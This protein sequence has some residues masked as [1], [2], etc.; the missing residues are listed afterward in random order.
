M[1]FFE[2]ER[3]FLTCALLTAFKISH[4]KIR[5]QLCTVDS[6]FSLT[7]FQQGTSCR[8]VYFYFYCNQALLGIPKRLNRYRN[9][10][11][12]CK[13][14]KVSKTIFLPEKGRK[15]KSKTFPLNNTLQVKSTTTL[16]SGFTIVSSREGKYFDLS[17]FST[18][19]E[20]T[21]ICTKN[22]VNINFQFCLCYSLSL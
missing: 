3:I 11:L 6:H 21:A 19:I 7:S 8:I 13:Q 22:L 4:L 5:L 2:H 17:Q 9:Y 1:S 18:F 12:Y 14:A 10:Y 15:Y 16:Q 20:Y